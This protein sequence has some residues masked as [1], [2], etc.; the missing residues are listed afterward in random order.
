[1]PAPNQTKALHP[2]AMGDASTRRLGRIQPGGRVI[3]WDPPKGKKTIFYTQQP[4]TRRANGITCGDASPKPNK[5]AS[6]QHYG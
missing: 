2:N 6:S 4:T 5:G 3:G 1:M